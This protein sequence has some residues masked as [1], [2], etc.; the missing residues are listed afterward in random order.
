[1]KIPV[2]VDGGLKAK[3]HPIGATGVS[4]A[5]EAYKQLLQKAEPGRQADIKKGRWL[6]HNIGGTG[7]FAYVTIY[8][9]EKR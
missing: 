5:V 4:Q 6:A 9:L 8:G 3:G 2:N 1:G 7:H